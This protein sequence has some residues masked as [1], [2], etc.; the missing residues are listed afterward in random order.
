MRGRHFY[1]RYAY[2]QLGSD[3]DAEEAVDKTFDTVMAPVRRQGRW[4][5]RCV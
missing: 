5:H 2:L 3:A 4:H 1:L